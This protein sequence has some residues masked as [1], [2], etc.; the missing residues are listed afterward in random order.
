MLK[1]NKFVI[2]GIVLFLLTGGEASARI[3]PDSLRQLGEISVVARTVSREVLP[4]QQLDGVR[5][6]RLGAHNVADALRYFSGVQIKDY[7]GVG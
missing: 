4:V 5:L 6:E 7:G 2:G 3:E 1:Q